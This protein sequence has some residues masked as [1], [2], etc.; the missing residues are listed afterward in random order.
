MGL[1]EVQLR[2]NR[3][4]DASPCP[5]TEDQEPAPP[6]R[7]THNTR[8]KDHAPAWPGAAP[9]SG[10]SPT[11]HLPSEQAATR[12]GRHDRDVQPP[13]PPSMS[14]A[15][16]GGDCPSHRLSPFGQEARFPA[17]MEVPCHAGHGMADLEEAPAQNA[18]NQSPDL[19]GA[20][21]RRTPGF[22]RTSAGIKTPDDHPPPSP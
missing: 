14:K 8:M 20:Q 1:P 15:K 19:R 18:S 2:Q 4:S 16:A 10:E 21:K 11:S 22:F 12:Q 17:T 6:H 7:V 9:A 13:S 5:E 3:R